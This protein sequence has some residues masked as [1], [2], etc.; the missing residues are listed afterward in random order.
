MDRDTWIKQI[1]EWDAQ[2]EYQKIINALEAISE[3]GHTRLGSTWGWHRRT[4]SWRPL[5]SG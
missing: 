4:A 2:E 1:E 3:E 5:M